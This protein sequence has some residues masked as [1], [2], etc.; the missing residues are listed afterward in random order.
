MASHSDIQ[1]IG[2]TVGAKLRAARLARKLTQSQL[3]QPD[4]SV[5]YVSAIER[6]QIHPSLRALEIFAQR[7]GISST[8]LLSKQTGP[9]LQGFSEKDAANENKQDT[10][11]QLLEAQLL[12]LRGDSRQAAT[13]LRSLSS[14]TLK[15]QQEIRQCYL[16]G[17]A[18]YHVGLLQESESVLT[19]ALNKT[20]LQNDFFV[21]HICNVLGL[22][23]VSMRN[24]T[25]GFEYQLRNVDQLEKEQLPHDAF[26]DAEVYTNIGLHDM[27]L[28]K[29]DDAIEMFQYAVNQTKEFQSPQQLTTMYWN[30]TRYFAESQQYFLATL[31]GYKILQLLDQENSDSMRSEVYH[32][33]G[34]AMLHQDQQ[35]ALMYLESLLQ[36]SSLEKDTLAFASITSTTAEVLFRKGEVKK[37]YEYAQKACKLA[38][39]YGDRIVTASIFLTCGSIAYARKDY[40]AGDAQ[41]MAGLSMLER[42]NNRE[43]LA[44][45]SALYAQLLEERGLPDEALKFYKQ[46]YESSLEHE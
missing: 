30:M 46:A 4:F 43:E 23:H 34:Q 19:E 20:L 44:D 16:L 22:V 5:S 2:H 21:K 10:E 31:Y 45:K 40:Q 8:E 1:W 17:V 25:Q 18:F 13:L 41:F 35:T 32:Y 33:L 26:F 27:D 6:G 39:A 15:S 42:L 37:A 24:H 38:L 9:V 7:L 29:I 36:E 28:D 12:I 11:L 3:A 14:D